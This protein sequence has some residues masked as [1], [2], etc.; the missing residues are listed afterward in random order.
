MQACHLLILVLPKPLTRIAL[1]TFL[2]VLMFSTHLTVENQ[3][4][5]LL[6][7]VLPVVLPFYQELDLNLNGWVQAGASPSN[8]KGA[9]KRTIIEKK[10]LLIPDLMIIAQKLSA[11]YSVNCNCGFLVLKLPI[12]SIFRSHSSTEKMMMCIS[13][14]LINHLA[15]SRTSCRES[16]QMPNKMT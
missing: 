2:L 14:H 4:S 1:C 10:I 3:A 5:G 13:K 15:R 9:C 12:H 7:R 16:D 8:G 11:S 6:L